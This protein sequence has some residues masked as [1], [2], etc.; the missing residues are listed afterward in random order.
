M[1]TTNPNLESEYVDLDNSIQR[2]D[3]DST[4]LKLPITTFCLNGLMDLNSSNCP[5]L[6]KDG[7]TAESLTVVIIAPIGF[8]IL[9]TTVCDIFDQRMQCNKDNN[10]S[11]MHRDNDKSGNGSAMS[12]QAVTKG[13]T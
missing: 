3:L 5:P 4:Y 10:R 2:P 13:L 8:K 6:F 11:V 9:I 12:S 7:T 1:S